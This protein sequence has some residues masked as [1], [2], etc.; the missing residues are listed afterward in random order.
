MERIVV[1]GIGAITPFGVGMEQCYRQLI[2]GKSA[3]HVVLDRLPD[4]VRVFSLPSLRSANAGLARRFPERTRLVELFIECEWPDAY[5]PVAYAVTDKPTQPD[6]IGFAVAAAT[7]ALR[8]CERSARDVHRTPR[9]K[10]TIRRRK[11]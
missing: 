6:V 10:S 3:I 7:E 5:D 2:R 4:R 8:V 9:W 11:R 1:T